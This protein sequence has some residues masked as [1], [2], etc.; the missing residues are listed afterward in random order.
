MKKGIVLIAGLCLLLSI[1][2]AWS[3]IKS[4][5]AFEKKVAELADHVL[6]GR[7]YDFVAA[8]VDLMENITLF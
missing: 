7:E 3:E 8:K 4:T 5:M 6:N 2:P 1:A